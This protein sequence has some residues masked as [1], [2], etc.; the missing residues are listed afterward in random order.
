M[1]TVILKQ[2][3]HSRIALGKVNLE[4]DRRADLSVHGGEHKA[5]YCHPLVHY[6][7]R[8]ESCQAE[9]CRWASLGKTSH[10]MACWKSQSISAI[11]VDSTEVVVTQPRLP[12]YKLG[13]RFEADDTVKRFFVSGRTGFRVSTSP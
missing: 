9:S 12:C 2:P 5:V 7:Y 8:K 1:T 6:D 11:S 13:V 3:V 10:S 4:G